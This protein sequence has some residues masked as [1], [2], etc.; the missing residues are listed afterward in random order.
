MKGVMG[1][2]DEEVVSSDFITCPFSSIFDKKACIALNDKFVKLVSWYDNE[3]GYSNRLIDLACH[4]AQVDGIVPTPSKIVSIKAREIFDSRGNPTVEVDLLTDM[5]LFRAAVPSGAST[6]VYEAL[7]LRD[8]DKGRLL[9]K[10]VLK[11]VDNVNNIIAPKIKGYDVTKQA[12][13]DKIMVE[14]LDGSQNEWGWSKAKLGANAIL[15]VSMAVARAGAAASQMPLYKYLARLSSQPCDNYVMPVP[16]F[17]VI[18]GGSHAGNRLACQEF[19]I[20]PVGA[21][22]FK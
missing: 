15:A 17:N 11:A 5:H 16:S 2:T 3:W 8:G 18:N 13:I 12:E 9:G 4:M 20:L 1:F 6:G 10:G 21:S 7:E 22:T 19:M 14:T